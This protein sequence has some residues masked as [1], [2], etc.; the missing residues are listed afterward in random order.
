[1]CLKMSSSSQRETSRNKLWDKAAASLLLPN[2]HGIYLGIKLD[3]SYVCAW[4]RA[5]FHI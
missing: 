3:L 1:M 2:N 4:S 5:T